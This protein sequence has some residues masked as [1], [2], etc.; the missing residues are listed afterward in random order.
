MVGRLVRDVQAAAGDKERRR[1]CWHRGLNAGAVVRQ[2]RKMMVTLSLS[3]S[4]ASRIHS[5]L[6]T[7]RALKEARA[8]E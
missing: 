7:Q 8:T 6:S 1:R 5:T 4:L 2:V 3:L